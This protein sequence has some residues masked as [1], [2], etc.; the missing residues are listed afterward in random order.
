MK[1]I[2]FYADSNRSENLLH[3]ETDGCVVN[4]HVGLTNSDGQKITRVDVLPEDASRG[5]DGEGR[6]WEIDPDDGVGV[7]RV[8]QAKA[9]PEQVEPTVVTDEQAEAVRQAIIARYHLWFERLDG[10]NPLSRP[11]DLTIK[12]DERGHAVISWE[13][14]SPE[15]WA[16]QVSE[17][18]STESDRVMITQANDEFG[19]NL[20][21]AEPARVTFP[22]GV[23]VEPVTSFE[24]GVYPT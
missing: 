23:H 4:I 9:T 22:D 7:A 20:T 6:I 21:A 18:G 10:M 17:G 12:R 8:V 16:F 1:T 13:N 15:D 2:R 19:G 11:E 24:L 3:I 14:D 5:G